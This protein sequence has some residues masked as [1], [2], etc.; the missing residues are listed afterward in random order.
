MASAEASTTAAMIPP[1]LASGL[2]GGVSTVNAPETNWR[3]AV[4][5]DRRTLGSRSLASA[6]NRWIAAGESSPRSPVRRAAQAR[7]DASLSFVYLSSVASSSN[8]EPC[9]VQSAAS[10]ASSVLPAARS[11][12]SGPFVFGSRRSL[13][14][15][16]AMRRCQM[17]GWASSSTSRALL[18]FARFIFLSGRLGTG[19]PGL[20]PT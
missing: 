1:T 18:N 7:T 13:R 17:F 19:C 9:K 15:R 11:F 8:S 20:L 5:T 12:S 16:C 14:S 4:A 10:R 3:A 2:L 6:A